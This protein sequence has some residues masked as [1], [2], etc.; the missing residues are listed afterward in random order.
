MKKRTFLL[1]LL[2]LL[3]LASCNPS[4]TSS[5]SSSTSSNTTET[6]SSSSSD[7]TSSSST[8]IEDD[9]GTAE[10]Q[11]IINSLKDTSHTVNTAQYVYVNQTEELAVD[12]F[13]HSFNT[14]VYSYMED[15][16]RA[17]SRQT[18]AR[19]GNLQKGTTSPEVDEDGNDLI[20]YSYTPREYFFKDEDYG[21]VLKEELLPSN[22]IETTIQS[23]YDEDTGLYVP[24]IFEDEFKNPFDYIQAR[25]LTPVDGE[26]N[27]YYLTTD[28]AEFLLKCY[29]ATASNKIKQAVIYTDSTGQITNIKMT[30]PDEGGDGYTYTR[31]T[32]YEVTYSDIGDAST[33]DHLTTLPTGTNAALQTAFDTVMNATNYS[34][35]KR[36]MTEDETSGEL[37]IDDDIKG[38][39]TDEAVFFHHNDSTLDAMYEVGDDYDYAAVKQSDNTYLGYE[40]IYSG[41][42]WGWSSIY[43]STST[44]YTFDSIQEIGPKLTE[45]SADVFTL[46]EGTTNTYEIRDELLYLI[47]SYFDFQFLGVNSQVLETNTVSFELVLEDDGSFTVNTSYLYYEYGVAYT[48]DF[49]FYFDASSVNNTS[50]PSFF[51]MPS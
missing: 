21:V 10:A 29:F 31:I 3:V 39:F 38:Y 20:S 42:A 11:A 15:G 18:E 5:T 14:L 37:V 44:P 17:V 50:M 28:K 27:A 25:D 2:S 7:S 34:Y 43:I 41:T 26:D 33:F 30:T 47:A 8:I 13:Y 6:S 36:Y 40:Y 16:E 9:E 4:G 1:P 24:V 22:E 51:N 49:Q 46:K 23:S 19:H 45:V 12:T 32:S 35:E 48:Q